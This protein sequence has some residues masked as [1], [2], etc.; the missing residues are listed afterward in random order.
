ML[1]LPLDGPVNSQDQTGSRK[2]FPRHLSAY[3][4][5]N[6]HDFKG[7]LNKLRK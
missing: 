1:L 3:I 2:T 5:L 7:H 6:L 4:S